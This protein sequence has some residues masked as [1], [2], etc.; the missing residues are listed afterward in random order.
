MLKQA[1]HELHQLLRESCVDKGHTIEHSISVVNHVN[2][3]IQSHPTKYNLTSPQLISVQLAALLHDADDS[4]FF[5]TTTA[6]GYPNAITIVKKVCPDYHIHKMVVDM[7]SLVSCSENRNRVPPNTPEFYLLPRY[8]DR[9]EATGQIGIERAYQYSKYID[10]PLFNDNT[11]RP[12]TR[13][14]IEALIDPERFNSYTKSETMIDH[15]YDKILHIHQ[16]LIQTGN[17]YLVKKA[18]E[19]Y[20][21]VIDFLIEFGKTGEIKID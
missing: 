16:P 11:P 9:L 5:S 8:A 13:E 18:Q 21:Q 14:E 17:P 15:F 1:A 2:N 20:N 4:K 12:T 7:I 3:I 10:R 19:R 6:T